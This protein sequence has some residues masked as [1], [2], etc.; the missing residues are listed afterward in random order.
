MKFVFCV[1]SC[2][3]SRGEFCFYFPSSAPLFQPDDFSS[4][5]QLAK[6]LPQS[7]IT[8]LLL[9]KALKIL[10]T[11]TFT[12]DGG[13]RGLHNFLFFMKP[14]FPEP[15]F[16]PQGYLYSF[17]L[18]LKFMR[19]RLNIWNLLVRTKNN[20]PKTDMSAKQDRSK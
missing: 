20:K 14:H 12:N 13:G 10:F 17:F 19:F 2:K 4:V 6:P 9:G 11:Y 8:A 7:R 15:F 5:R 18:L 3:G 16:P 1:W